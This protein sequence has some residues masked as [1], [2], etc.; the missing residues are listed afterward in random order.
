RKNVPGVNGQPTQLPNE[1]DAACPLER[2]E[3]DFT[4]EAGRTHLR[5]YRHV[6]NHL[7]TFVGRANFHASS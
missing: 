5:L 6:L 1:I 7:F 2:P 3:W 4:T